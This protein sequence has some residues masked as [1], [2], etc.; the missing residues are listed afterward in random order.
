MHYTGL[1]FLLALGLYGVY[2]ISTFRFKK[3]SGKLLVISTALLTLTWVLYA[4]AFLIQD[5][6]LAEVA[7][8][9][10]IGLDWWLKFAASWSSTGSSLLLFSFFI[11]LFIFAAYLSGANVN[12]LR[13]ST[14]FLLLVGASVYLYGSFDTISEATVGA[15]LNP[16]LK[17]FW[18]TIHPPLVFLGYA[19]VLVIS[20]ALIYGEAQKLKRL[21][22]LALASL[23]AG[24]VVGGYWSYVTFGWGGYWAWDPVETAQLTAFVVAAAALHAPAALAQLRRGAYLLAISSV[25]LGL[26][27]TRTGM[28]PLHGFGEPGLGGYLLITLALLFFFAFLRDVLTAKWGEVSWGRVITFITI[29]VAG[30]LL[31][32]SLLVPSLGVA[33][34]FQTAPPQ[35]DDGMWFYNP[36]LYILVVL[37]L[38]LAPLIYLE[39]LGKSFWLYLGAGTAA[40]AAVVGLVW[41]GVLSFSP[42]SHIL[43]NMAIGAALIWSALGGSVILYS[44]FTSKNR[45]TVLVRLLHFTLLLFFVAAVYS[46]PFAYNR[47]YFI[48]M[49]IT[50]GASLKIA[51]VEISVKDYELGLMKDKVDIYTLYK[52]NVVYFYAQ[53]GMFA[54]TNLLAQTR[55]AVEEAKRRIEGNPLLRFIFD[56]A[57]VP[58]SVGDVKCRLF[59]GSELVIMNASLGSYPA[60]A[61]GGALS[62]LIYISGRFGGGLNAQAPV[63][64][65]EPCLVNV[66]NFVVNMSGRLVLQGSGEY[67]VVI[68]MVA[69]ISAS[70]LKVS[71]PYPLDMNLTLY[72]MTFRPGMPLYGLLDVPYYNLLTNAMFGH[73]FLQKF[74][75][76]IPSGAYMRTT[77]LINGVEN[78]AVVRYEV[79]GEVSGI[80]GLVSSVVHMPTGLDDVYIAVFTPY[81]RGSMSSYPEPMVY[82]MHNLLKTTPPEDALRL[83][84]LLT[85]GFFLDQFRRAGSEY[86]TLFTSAY[87]EV[88]NLAYNYD[89]SKSPAYTE[90]I[91]MS[92]K[93][94]PLINL[95]WASSLFITLLLIVLT[96]YGKR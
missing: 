20:S 53:N 51:G 45:T 55:P 93:T 10:N 87:L 68:P 59:N 18:I 27:V 73:V 5:F 52:N 14:I 91:H 65:E 40:T 3:I 17:S 81:I 77:L 36:A 4:V 94:V 12:A 82:Y 96:I 24:L 86:A 37:T 95:L 46:L 25:F 2:L 69:T 72:Y 15:G 30:L 78:H 32:G 60:H 61:S 22:Y 74:P 67:V 41:A 42:K 26:Y 64:L 88:L 58:I 84:A 8:N 71:I 44:A 47:G 80:H 38:I 7:K 56:V 34:G 70:N 48:D 89:L 62:M 6:S 43:T 83:I 76:I 21:L 16:L 33:V 90:G 54:M 49:Y 57:K 39:R 92:I 1:L 9:T 19:G 23:F 28:S 63:A 31:Y 50:P 13:L 75:G 11:G 66:G 35:L 85:T 79:N 29:F